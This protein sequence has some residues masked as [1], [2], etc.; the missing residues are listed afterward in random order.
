MRVCGC[1][2]EIIMVMRSLY[3]N[4]PCAA[5]TWYYA[6]VLEL[7]QHRNTLWKDVKQQEEN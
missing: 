6:Y 5:P 3:S 2:M 4:T 7:A 1:C